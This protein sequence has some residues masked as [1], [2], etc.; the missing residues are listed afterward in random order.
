MI[1]DEKLIKGLL[2]HDKQLSTDFYLEC[3][4][5]LNYI[6]THYYW[7]YPDHLNLKFEL[8]HELYLYIM[9]DD[10]QILRD[11]QGRCSLKTYFFSVGFNYLKSLK[12]YLNKGGEVKEDISNVEKYLSI[13]LEDSVF[14]RKEIVRETLKRMPSKQALVLK[15]LYFE[16]YDLK[17][18]SQE[19]NIT[20][21][22][23]Y[24]LNSVAKRN[25]WN[26]FKA[27]PTN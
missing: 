21:G 11:F 18:L 6:I 12:L 2:N 9:K 17:K 5:I 1:E 7:N 23:I 8:A 19:L 4:D 26:T 16:G 13:P 10:A 24:N 3:E 25:F 27:F 15:K 22:S 20:I 14:N